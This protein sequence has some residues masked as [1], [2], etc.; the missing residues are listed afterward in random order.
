[1]HPKLYK[2]L[3]KK[4]ITDIDNIINKNYLLSDLI[5]YRGIKTNIKLKV[6]DK[7]SQKSFF[8]V[9]LHPRK[10]ATFKGGLKNGLYL[11]KI[12]LPKYQ[13]YIFSYN[14]LNPE[15]EI[16]LPRNIYFKV[17]DKNKDAE[18]ITLVTEKLSHMNI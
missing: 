10:S 18:I 8:S 13:N 15:Y 7:F 14:T 6:G 1:L 12:L 17:I 5:V 3:D 11:Y 4:N 2:Y 9:S 16:I